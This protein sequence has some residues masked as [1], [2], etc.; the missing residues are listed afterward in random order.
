MANRKAP[1]CAKC[2]VIKCWYTERGGRVPDFCPKETYADV[3]QKTVKKNRADPEIRRINL[4]FEAIINNGRD[5][6]GYKWTRVKEVMEYAKFLKYKKI[7][8]AFCIGLFEEA[9]MLNNILE[10]NGFEVVSVCCMAGGVNA[11][12]LNIER[13]KYG[14]PLMCNPLMQ[15][16][17]LNREE[18]E[19][20]I[21]FGLCVG[22]DILF[23]RYSK[24]DVTPLVVKDR[25]MAHNPIGALYTCHRYYREKL[26]PH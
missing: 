18:T 6:V 14:R 20:N 17:V 26:L 15:A 9:G 5:E 23:I 25:V 2:R 7:G 1:A 21:M 13:P 3:R 11:E 8:L 16:E 24:A 10:K 12:E 22:H 4:A 19:L